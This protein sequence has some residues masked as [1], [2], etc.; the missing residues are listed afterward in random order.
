MEGQPMNFPAINARKS[1]A[2]A[3][4][5]A[6]STA[7][8]ATPELA[9]PGAEGFG[10]LATGGRTG[11]IV[12]VTNLADAGPGSFREAVSEPDRFVVFDVGGVIKLKSNVAVANNITKPIVKTILADPKMV[13]AA[14]YTLKQHFATFRCLADGNIVDENP[15][16]RRMRESGM[17][18]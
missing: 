12:H 16:S 14:L 17:V 18:E 11:D 7:F 3:L 13:I 4:W 1:L 5:F 9:F 15:R 6:V 8:S 10:A 2:L